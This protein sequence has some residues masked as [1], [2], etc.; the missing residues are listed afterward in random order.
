MGSGELLMV[1]LSLTTLL[2]GVIVILAGLRYRAYIRELR[3]REHLAMIEKGMVP[4]PEPA[5]VGP[6][7]MPMREWAPMQRSRS[8][9]IILIG[10]GFAL[11]FLIGIAGGAADTGI[12][13][14]GAVA[15]LGG[16]FIARSF[17]AVSAGPSRWPETPPFPPAPP[18]GDRPTS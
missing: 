10:L 14:G 16:A 7:G 4:P 15:I 1:V 3:H 5:M 13:V 2:G 18:P 17:F 11:M 9:G 6:G 8:F 12:G